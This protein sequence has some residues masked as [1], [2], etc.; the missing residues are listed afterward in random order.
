MD[1]PVGISNFAIHRS[2][3][4]CAALHSPMRVLITEAPTSSAGTSSNTSMIEQRSV[5]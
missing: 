5:S 1:L 2:L 3:G 4:W